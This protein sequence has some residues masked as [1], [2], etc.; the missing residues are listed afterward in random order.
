MTIETTTVRKL[1]IELERLEIASNNIRSIIKSLEDNE[2]RLP[3]T[4]ALTFSRRF[5]NIHCVDRDGTGIEIGDNVDILTKGKHRSTT[6]KVI[7]YSNNFTRVFLI[8][9]EGI[10]VPRAPHNLRIRNHVGI[11]H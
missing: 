8:D 6:G 2:R 4:P 1:Y 7:R 5:P 3:L 10:E 11:I 9:S